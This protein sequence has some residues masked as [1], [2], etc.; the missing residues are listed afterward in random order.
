MS[1][2]TGQRPELP[3][4]L[5]WKGFSDP[6]TGMQFEAPVVRASA[7]SPLSRDPDLRS[8]YRSANP[9]HY[10]VIVAPSGLACEEALLGRSARLLLR[11]PASLPV[12]LGELAAQQRA[13]LAE[14]GD[15][16][17]HFNRERSL[18]CV[19]E[20]WE[21]ALLCSPQLR[22]A[23]HEQAGLALR[24]SWSLRELIEHGRQEEALQRRY[25]QLRAIALAR[26]RES[27]EH[28]DLSGLKLGYPGCGY[29]IG[30]LHRER[31]EYEEAFRWLARVA[32]DR[33]TPHELTRLART[34]LELSQEQRRSCAPPEVPPMDSDGHAPPGGAGAALS[35][36][37]SPAGAAR[38]ATVSMGQIAPRP[39][40]LV[41]TPTAQEREGAVSLGGSGD[42]LDTDV[43]LLSLE[44]AQRP[45][46]VSFHIPPPLSSETV[47]LAPGQLEWLDAWAR[48]R[49]LDSS[50]VLRAFI[51]AL[52]LR[53]YAPGA[54]S[55]TDLELVLAKCLPGPRD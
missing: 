48:M 31:G 33:A 28:E 29:L 45:F 37:P 21:L 23:R 46:T 4:E 13:A 2:R 22:L 38:P 32:Q 10:N 24:A 34:R 8:T 3:R 6:F 40:E 49:G 53:G 52:Q 17:Q 5:F 30:E 41:L 11:D 47:R 36:G 42:A 27:Y 39:V 18:E 54:L 15:L 44:T 55:E 26:Y 19:H 20:A 1:R 25:A 35:H 16:Y 7:I 14:G 50:A 43:G 9:Q 12:F 51:S